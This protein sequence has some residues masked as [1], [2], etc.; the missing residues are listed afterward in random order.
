MHRAHIAGGPTASVFLQSGC[1][2]R[3]DWKR[4]LVPVLE[5]QTAAGRRDNGGDEVGTE[6]VE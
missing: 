1:K 4:V 6:V 2:C 5:S 3:G